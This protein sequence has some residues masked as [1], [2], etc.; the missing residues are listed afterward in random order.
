MELFDFASRQGF[1]RGYLRT[2]YS[3]EPTVDEIQLSRFLVREAKGL[4]RGKYLELGCGPTLHH[5]FPIAP[6]VREIHLLDYLDEN[7]AEVTAWQ[8]RAPGA[9]DWR[10]FTAMSLRDA[11]DDDGAEAVAQREALVRSRITRIGKCNLMQATPA[12]DRNAYAAVGCFYVA[13]EVGISPEAWR[14]VMQ[15]VADYVAPGGTLLMAAL[16]NMTSYHVASVSGP[17][18]DYPCARVTEPMLREVLP[19]LG[20]AA[21]DVRIEALDIDHP[22]CGLTATLMVA[23][24]KPK[25]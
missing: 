1:A 22:D 18:S 19:A 11:G 16:A 25:S 20:F 24:K 4:P 6:H 23:A 12:A 5:V 7:L 10:R 3:G 21:G 14:Q 15:R 9:H 13:E 17:G 8:R 2:Y